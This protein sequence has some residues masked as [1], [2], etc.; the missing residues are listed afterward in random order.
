ME[1]IQMVPKA[2][3][4]SHTPFEPGAFPRL[5][6]C[7]SCAGAARLDVGQSCWT[8]GGQHPTVLKGLPPSTD[9]S[10]VCLSL[11]TV[12]CVVWV[13]GGWAGGDVFAVMCLRCASKG[14]WWERHAF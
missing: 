1:Q 13:G 14:F 10:W 7:S 5:A 11:S 12:R 3:G 4:V 8:R 2:D 6:S 9:P